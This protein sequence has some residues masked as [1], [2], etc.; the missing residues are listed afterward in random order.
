MKAKEVVLLLWRI[1]RCYIYEKKAAQIGPPFF[2]ILS[3]LS[4]CEL[5][6]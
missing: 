5:C 1:Q 4:K 6:Q 2:D 3:T